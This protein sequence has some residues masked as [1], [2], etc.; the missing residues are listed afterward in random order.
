MSEPSL[1]DQVFH[2]IMKRMVAT[3]PFWQ[4]PSKV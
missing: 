2:I 1:L 4:L 3:G